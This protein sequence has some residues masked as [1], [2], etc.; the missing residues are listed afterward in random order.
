MCVMVTKDLISQSFPN[1][2]SA[3]NSLDTEALFIVQGRDVSFQIVWDEGRHN[4]HMNQLPRSLSYPFGCAPHPKNFQTNSAGNW[5][6][7]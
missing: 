7:L 6:R 1:I 3:A 5:K 4:D 2:E